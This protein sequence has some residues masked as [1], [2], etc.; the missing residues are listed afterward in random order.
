MKVLALILAC[1][2][3]TAQGRSAKVATTAVGRAAALGENPWVVHLRLAVSTSGFLNSCAGSLI[4]SSWVLTSAGCIADARFI[5]IRYG[6]V[7]V[8]NPELVTETTAVRPHATDDIAVVGINRFVASTD[9]IAPVGLAS[10]DA[11]MP[12]AGRFCA[13]GADENDAPAELL[14]C[15]DVELSSADGL[16]VADVSATRFDVGA[17]LVSDGIQVG[18]AVSSADGE[19]MTLIKINDKITEFIQPGGYLA[20]ISQQTGIPF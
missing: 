8:V 9:N 17:P 20:W 15:Y 10:S 16:L 2:L 13:W 5:W 19:T 11:E 14:Q 7:N 4:S 1:A 18:L 6:L 3:A 12:S